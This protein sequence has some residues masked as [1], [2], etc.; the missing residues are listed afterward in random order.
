MALN[1]SN[2]RLVKRVRQGA[3]HRFPR[4]WE[5]LVEYAWWLRLNCKP[6]EPRLIRQTRR[7]ADGPVPAV[8]PET[9]KTVLFFQTRSNPPHLAWAGTLAKAL[10]TRGHRTVFLGCS[11]ELARSCNNANY[12]EGLSGSRCRTCFRYTRRYLLAADFEAAWIGEFVDEATVNRAQALVNALTP[13]EYNG[14]SYRDLPLGRLTR[15]SVGHYL[16]TGSIG[17]DATS[18]EMYRQFLISAVL[19][20]D[21]SLALMKSYEPDVVVMLGGLFMPERIMMEVARRHG[22]RVVVYEIGMLAQDALMFQHDRPTDYNDAESWAQYRDR[23]LTREENQQL[24]KYLVERSA[25]RMSVIN[26]WPEKIENRDLIYQMLGMDQA[27]RTAVLFPNI[28][29]DSAVFEQDIAFDG[30]FDWLDRTIEYFL[31]H[32]EFQLVIRAHPAE[33]ILPGSTRESVAGYIEKRFP[34]L[35]KHI[36][37]VPSESKVSSYTLMDLSHCGLSYA[38]TTAIELGIRGL[39]VLVAGRVHYREKG[40]TVD[41]EDASAYADQLDD[42]MTALDPLVREQI[43]E[44]AR[45][46]AY[47]VFFRTSMPFHTVH[48][49]EREHPVLTYETVSDLLPGRDRSLDIICSGVIAG[50][51]FLYE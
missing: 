51:P 24:D 47:F 43:R 8:P 10:E 46:Y 39:P 40:F 17:E 12:P 13:A 32:P 44:M 21:T 31:K 23:P 29:W 5:T 49:G 25:G 14:L 34:V 4:A 1:L 16:R 19:I 50:T 6:L 18:R 48:C 3:Q 38:S 45:R 15:H 7:L 26:Y 35:P 33:R 41:V 42:V 22:K 28:T 27:K 2:H 36:I 9:S 11:R 20:A 37:V 30:M